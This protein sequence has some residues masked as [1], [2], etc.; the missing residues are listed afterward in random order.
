MSDSFR[1]VETGGAPA[2]IGPYSQG[3]VAGDLVFTAGQIGL[4]PETGD[5]VSRG[6]VPQFRRAM[7]SIEA[8]LREAGTNLDQVVKTTVYFA[9]LSDFTAVNEVYA[10]YFKRPYPARSAV[11]A[12][13]LPKGARIEVEVI[14]RR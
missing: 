12:A 6:T 2:A 9:D 13:A 14:A 8:I 4:D 11:Q 10:E 1:A 7:V 5:L 3:V